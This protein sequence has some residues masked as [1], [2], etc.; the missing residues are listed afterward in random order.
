MFQRT[1]SNRGFTLIEMLICIAIIAILCGI[2]APAFGKL[3]G[4]T[5]AQTARSQLTAAFNEARIAAVSH[6]THVVVCPSVDQHSCSDTMQWRRGWIVF[7]DANHNRELD[8]EETLLS[9]G[10]TLPDG[11][12]VVG[13]I[14]RLRIDYQ[15]DGS[16]RGTNAT[17]TVCDRASGAAEARTL[18]ISQGGRVRYGSATAANAA[19]CVNAAG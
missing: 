18:V 5:Q 7:L 19:A 11:V 16:A 10:Q 9:V 8:G 1:N 14:G 12:A 13:S 4:K 17:L 2:A 3:I 15:P 6:E